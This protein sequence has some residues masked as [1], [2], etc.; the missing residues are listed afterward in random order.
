M[1]KTLLRNQLNKVELNTLLLK[2]K[3]GFSENKNPRTPNKIVEFLLLCTIKIYF[4]SPHA[5]DIT[6]KMATE[7]GRTGESTWPFRGVLRLLIK[8]NV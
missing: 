7:A 3:K 6:V 4:P 5:K 1:D 2:E 8:I